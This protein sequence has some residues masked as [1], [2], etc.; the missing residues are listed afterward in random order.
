MVSVEQRS[1][2]IIPSLQRVK[3]RAFASLEI[4]NKD[5]AFW[6]AYIATAEGTVICPLAAIFFGN[7]E[8]MIGALSVATFEVARNGRHVVREA[9]RRRT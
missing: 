4:R 3:D 9:F 2:Q 8:I 6:K 5:N 1:S 7:I